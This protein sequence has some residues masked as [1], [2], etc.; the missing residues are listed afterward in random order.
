VLDLPMDTTT[1]SGRMAALTMA[2]VAE[3]ER[4][5]NSERTSDALQAKKAAGKRLGRPRRT[6]DA[7]LDRIRVQRDNGSTWQAIADRL[8]AEGVPTTRGGNEWQVGTVQAAYRTARLDR[9][10]DGR[11]RLLADTAA[12]WWP[13][14]PT[15]RRRSVARGGRRR[16]PPPGRGFPDVARSAGAYAGVEARSDPGGGMAVMGRL[17]WCG[18]RVGVLV[19]G[20]VALWASA[21][22]APAGAV[23]VRVSVSSA[24]VQGNDVSFSAAVSADGRY[25][26]FSSAAGNLVAGDTNGV[27]D[28]FVRDL[29]TGTT[30]R[31]SVSSAGVQGNGGSGVGFP[32]VVISADGRYVAFVSTAS[33]LV[34]GDTNGVEDIFVRDVVAGTTRRVSVA[35]GGAQAT[36]GQVTCSEAPAISADGRFVA[37]F[38]FASNLVAGDT[39]GA[40]D[41]FV[42]NLAAGTTGRVSVSSGRGVQGNGASEYGTAISADGRFVAFGSSASN[43]VVGDTNRQ[44]DVFVRDRAMARTGRVSV[45]SGRGVQGNGDSS[46]PAISADGRFVVF[47]SSASN[48]VVGDTNRSSDVF[49]RD[50]AKATTRR[51]SL[52]S[53]G[54]QGNGNSGFN[55]AISADGRFVTFDSH[56]SN[57]VA[58]D[59]NLYTDIFLRDRT[60]G[61]TQRVSVS[62]TG[63]QAGGPSGD[64][65]I[66]ADG[67]YI[68]FGS[69]AGNLVASDTNSVA[70]VFVRGPLA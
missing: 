17:E 43:L 22:A 42:R 59:T 19:V 14:T 32:G 28:V 69:N 64:P 35:S 18:R 48:L 45:A 53:A 41:V 26:A 20:V 46:L 24:G 36:C 8:N 49:V 44:A 1:A 29:G 15:S 10:A 62:S 34:A 33:N 61:I 2:N 60:T 47:S 23:T 13:T 4:G 67:H 38:S 31:V 52:S 16:F 5:I 56:A 9:L 63:L 68:A 6:P 57:L 25:V 30:R 50:R 7:I 11:A 40:P 21:V 3:F 37:F 54:V 58:G 70:D 55:V 27:V 51:V 12:R 39:N 66:S 65:A